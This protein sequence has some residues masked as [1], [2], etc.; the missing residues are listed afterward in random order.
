M[1]PETSFE[2]LAHPDIT[3][4]RQLAA[5]PGWKLHD[6]RHSALTRAAENG[7][8]TGTL[9]AYSGHASVAS[10]A[11]CPSPPTPS[12]AGRPDA[13]RTGAADQT[14]RHSA[15]PTSATRPKGCPVRRAALRLGM[16]CGYKRSAMG[17]LGTSTQMPVPITVASSG[18]GSVS[19]TTLSDVGSR[20]QPVMTWHK[21][22]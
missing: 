2:L 20:H 1:P 9:L 11:R 8:N 15:K 4:P 3:D 18:S 10:L 19:K 21:S 5:A 16:P 6:L 22:G 12:P 7:A 14:D 17:P 13:T